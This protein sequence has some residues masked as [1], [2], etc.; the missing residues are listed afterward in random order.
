[1]KKVWFKHGFVLGSIL[2]MLTIIPV[3]VFLFFSPIIVSQAS[4][5][6]VEETSGIELN[7]KSKSLLKDSSY[8]LRVYNTKAKQKIFFRSADSEIVSVNKDGVM[9][10]KNV[11]TTT[12]NVIIKEGFKT[13]ETLTCEVIVGLPAISVKFT[14][15]EVNLVVGNKTTLKTILMPTDTI[16]EPTYS[17]SD[18]EI[19][20][21]TSTGRI[22]AKNPG[23]ATVT[24][25]IYATDKDGKYKSD[26]CT[27]IVIEAPV[28]KEK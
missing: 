14:K 21:I 17:I 5:V 6:K 12:I 26:T 13:V 27:I 20:T 22:I 4:E 23:Q 19:A 18:S 1:M 11:G 24:A 2:F 9:T 10:G 7:V 16:E 3:P 15:A 28:E 8:T 25:T